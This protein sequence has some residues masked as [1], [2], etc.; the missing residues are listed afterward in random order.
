MTDAAVYFRAMARNNA[1]ANHRLLSACTRLSDA[2]FQAE[3][4][5]FFPGIMQTLNHLLYV[6]WFYVDALEGG[7]L[8]PK[9]WADETPCPT[10]AALVPAQQAVDR[11]LVAFCDRLD[12]AGF[13]VNVFEHALDVMPCFGIGRPTI[14]CLITETCS[15]GIS[16][17]DLARIARQSDRHIAVIYLGSGGKG[18][19]LVQGVPRSEL[20]EKG[21]TPDRIL[22]AVETALT[23]ADAEKEAGP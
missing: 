23:R 14:D 11:R 6:D 10:V 12:D 17:W 19:W 8:G 5:S 16:G 4:V 21:W 13:F 7:T 2:E 20:L 3:R 1:W 9:A 22:Q 18:E 15:F